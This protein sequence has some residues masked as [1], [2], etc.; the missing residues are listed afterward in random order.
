MQDYN[1]IFSSLGVLA[2]YNVVSN[3]KGKDELTH[4]EGI[5]L[6]KKDAYF[7]EPPSVIFFKRNGKFMYSF[8]ILGGSGDK[9]LYNYSTPQEDYDTLE[10]CIRG[11]AMNHVV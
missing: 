1:K 7:F 4:P 9:I 10:E 5:G 8:L 6:V 2:R 3:W 11:A